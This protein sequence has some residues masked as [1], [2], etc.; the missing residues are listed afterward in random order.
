MIK[1]TNFLV[2]KK[3]SNQTKRQSDGNVSTAI[4]RKI[5]DPSIRVVGHSLV[6]I[7]VP[8]HGA[9]SSEIVVT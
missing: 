4:G 3:K 5:A 2:T 7:P 8:R 6:T 1:R 9:T